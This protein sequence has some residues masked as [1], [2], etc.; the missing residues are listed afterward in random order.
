MNLSNVYRL[1][2]LNPKNTN[3]YREYYEIE[4]QM[5][6]KYL[7][8]NNLLERNKDILEVG[9]GGGVFYE[10]YKN[11][12]TGLNNKYTCID[13]DE[14][15]IRIS[16][17]KVDFV[18]FKC[19]DIHDYP[20]NELCKHNIILMVQTYICIPK[21]NNIIKKYFEENIYGKIIMINTIVPEYLCGISNIGREL[22]AKAWFGV[23]WGK[24][25]T[26]KYMIELGQHLNRRLTYN[27][28][29]QSPL[30][31]H[32]EYIMVLY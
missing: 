27:I 19:L 24:A 9:C 21:I 31:G 15:S 2:T 23:N 25:L 18:K 1:L 14:P 32:D 26:L 7:V 13:I 28:I 29:G 10:E 20:I 11:Y 22:I 6:Y 12:L 8:D 3:K 4:T 17:T 30:S 16:K 5:L